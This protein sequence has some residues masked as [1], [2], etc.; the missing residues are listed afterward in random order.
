MKTKQLAALFICSLIY[1][2]GGNGILP[3]LPVYA[4]SLGADSVVAGYY[5]SFSYLALALG[6]LAAGWLSDTVQRR[7]MLLATSIVIMSPAVWAMGQVGQVWL[8]VMLTAAV[9]FL[10]GMALTLLTIIAGLFAGRS[11]RGHVFG[12]LAAAN[13]LGSLVGGLTVG[14][15]ADRWGYPV[16]FAVIALVDVILLPLVA[17][18]VQDRAIVASPTSHAA[19]EGQAFGA[20]YLLILAAN[21]LAAIA[22]FSG[23]LGRSLGMKEMGFVGFDISSTVAVAGAVSLPLAPLVGRLSDRLGRRQLLAL[24]YLLGCLGLLFFSLSQALWQYWLAA[25]LLTVISTAGSSVGSA[26]VADLVPPQLLGRGMS[27][28]NATFWVGGIVGFTAMGHAIQVFGGQSAFRISALLPLIA[29]A[30]L[31][32]IRPVRRG[33]APGSTGASK[34]G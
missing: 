26:Y 17:F 24:G 8:L 1:W 6:S 2:T 15:I 11:E 12:I 14:A 29:I 3:L 5:L 18:F 20:G 30:V 19:G 16:V 23:Y 28:F 21:T 4:T 31:L 9:W 33:P 10:A 22:L 25:A 34:T 27:M 13:S 32:V 7:K